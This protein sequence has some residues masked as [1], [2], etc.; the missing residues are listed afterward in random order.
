MQKLLKAKINL[1]NLINSSKRKN[2]KIK[3]TF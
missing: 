2:R 3:G 1:N